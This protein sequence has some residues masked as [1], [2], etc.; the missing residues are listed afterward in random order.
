MIGDFQIVIEFLEAL[1]ECDRTV[2]DGVR[3]EG[4]Q[5]CGGPLHRGDFERKPRF[6]LLGVEAESFDT[7]FSLCCGSEGCRRR[8]TPPSLRFLGRRV[9]VGAVVI[10]ASIVALM[11]L[12]VTAARRATGVPARTLRRWGGWW[13]GPFV[14][15]PVFV[16]LSG[17]LVPAV[18]RDRLPASLLER[19]AV[20][21][22]ASLQKLLGGL[23]PITTASCPDASRFVRGCM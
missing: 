12:A 17:L 5:F 14:V 10:L 3:R 6:A 2:M 21:F 20:P 11:E 22:P 23:A 15:M 16:E 8:T 7:R 4:C 1:T 9:Y 13:Q 19:V 18:D